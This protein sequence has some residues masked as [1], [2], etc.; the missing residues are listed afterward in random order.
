M[1]EDLYGR[2]PTTPIGVTLSASGVVIPAVPGRK[3]RIFAALV[4]PLAAVQVT[5]QSGGTNISGTFSLAANG[6]FVLPLTNKAW[7]VT[8]VGQ[9]LTVVMSVSTTLGMQL[10]YDTSP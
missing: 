5:F 4:N 6:G 9:A 8:G 2:E 10:L 1:S 7:M 3:I